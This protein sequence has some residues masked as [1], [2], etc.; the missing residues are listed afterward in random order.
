MPLFSKNPERDRYYL[1]PGMG[2]R[3]VRRKRHTTLLWALVVGTA[4]SGTLA[5]VLYAIATIGSR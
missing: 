5:A 2:G 3:A 1:L 4:V